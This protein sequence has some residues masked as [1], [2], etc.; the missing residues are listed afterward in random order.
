M[1]NNDAK[2]LDETEVGILQEQLQLTLSQ[3]ILYDEREVLNVVKR[4]VTHLIEHSSNR[5]DVPNWT[6]QSDM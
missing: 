3:S 2:V 4:G 5:R 1:A 6:R